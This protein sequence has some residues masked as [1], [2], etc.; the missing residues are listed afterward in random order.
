M[1]K[2]IA[3]GIFIGFLFLCLI[4]LFCV[5]II[6]LYI[7]KVTNYTKLIY[8]KDI[9]FQ[10]SLNTTILETQE[11]VFA[12]ISGE[13]HDD[14]GQQ[15]TYI[16][17]QIENLKL[18]LP[19]LEDQL[20][21]LSQSVNNLSKSIRRISHSLN[22]QILLQQ[23]LIKAIAAEI[24]RINKNRRIEFVFKFDNASKRNFNNNQQIVLYRIF[25][26]CI[27]NILKHSRATQVQIDIV[28]QPQ[29]IMTI[30]DNGKG[31]DYKSKQENNQ[32]LGL[33][34]ISNK[35][36]I[37]DFVATFY[38]NPTEGTTITITEQ[39]KG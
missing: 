37:I 24:E 13:L 10:K 12:N 26:E 36:K 2:D 30:A 8:Q 5:L 21:P 27:N 18:D 32:T 19:H 14:A 9:D 35:A 20:K 23:D 3:L 16:N 34:S 33:N 7:N 28:Y 1:N 38:S 22:N 25:Q 17:I 31:F 39:I 11:Q 4:V 15:L 29:F 6:K